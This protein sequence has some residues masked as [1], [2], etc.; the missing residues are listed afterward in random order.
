MQLFFR[1]TERG[2]L[3]ITFLFRSCVAMNPEAMSPASSFEPRQC[4]VVFTRAL[5]MCLDF[6]SRHRQGKHT[7]THPIRSV[8][9]NKSNKLQ[10]TVIQS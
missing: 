8:Y 5:F 2:S 6:A 3:A 7:H 1:K 9:I 4:H 10:N